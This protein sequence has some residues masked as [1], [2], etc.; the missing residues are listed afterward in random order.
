MR[1]TRKIL[2]A[3]LVLMTLM[4]GAF[5]VTAS[6]AAGQTWT[7]AG[8]K[9]LCGTDWDTANKNNDMTYDSATD[10]YVKVYENV[11]AGTYQFKCAKDHKW[12][13]SYGNGSANYN[14]KVDKDGSTVTITLKGTTV[15][16]K[17][18]APACDHKY[19]VTSA[20]VTCLTGG[21]RT[22]TCSVCGDSYTEEKLDALGHSYDANGQ[23]V[24]CDATTTF[25]RVYVNNA[26]KWANVYCYTWDTNPYVA[27]PGAQMAID[28]ATGYYYYDIPE[29]FVN[30][31]FNN[32]GSTQSA[33]LK[34]PT[35]KA[36]VYNNSTKAWS[37]LH[38]CSFSDATCTEPAKCECGKT[39]G[40]ALGHNYVEG[41]CS[42]CGEAA[43]CEHEYERV[44]FGHPDIVAP[45]CT[46]PGVAVYECSKCWDT[47]T[48][49]APIDP[50]AHDF[51]Y[52]N[53]EVITPADCATM[54]DGL[55]KVTCTYCNETKEV[56]LYAMHNMEE[57]TVPATCT[58]N[59]SYRAECKVCGYVE[60][61]VIEAG[62]HCNYSITCGQTG[63]CIECGV[64]FTKEHQGD[65]ATCTDPMFCYNCWS[66]VGEALGHNFVEGVCSRCEAED[67]NY[68]PEAK[69]PIV[70]IS[71]LAEGTTAGGELIA[72]TGI[73]ASAGLAIDAN[74]KSIDGF[75]FTLRLKLG[76][77]M[78]VE[79]G[80]VKAGIEIKTN[81]AAK[82]IVYAISSSSSDSTRTLQL[83][84]LVDGA[85]VKLAETAG[86]DGAAIAKYELSVDAAG[87]YYLG[88]TKSGINLYYIAVEEVEAPA[89]VNTLVVGETNKIVV[90]GNTLNAAGAPIEWV[91]FVV[92]EKAHYEFTG[93]T[94]AFIYNKMDLADFTAC[95]C[96]FDGKAD[97][98]PGTYYICVGGVVA[99]EFNITVTMSAI[100]GGDEP[101]DP[102][103]TP[104]LPELVLGDNAVVIDGSQT[105]LVGK[106]V[107]WY[108][109]TP[110]NAGV[111][112]FA[113]SDLTVYIL[114]SQNMADLN[115]YV[116]A[117]GVA[118]LEAGVQY[119]VLVGK[120][121][122]TG[123]FTLN[124]SDGAAPVHKNIIVVGDNHYIISD[125]LLGIG[126]EFLAVEITE[127]GTYVITGGAPMQVYF[128]TVPGTLNE[129]S[130]H[131][132]NID[133]VSLEFV[134][135]FEVTLT[136]AGTYWIGFRYDHVGD[137]REFD[138]NISLKPASEQPD[139]TPDEQ[140]EQPEEKPEQPAPELSLFEKIMQTI[141]EFIAKITAWFKSFI[142]GLKK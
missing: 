46:T 111:Y 12:D 37:E 100:E 31:I 34:T 81:G 79:D 103:V 77:T 35:G 57:T 66:S 140:P 135:S 116:G 90:S 74:N 10:S 32:G 126:Y 104:A 58:E 22:W 52:D 69:L 7:V 68:V 26:A 87:T 123:E 105:N 47:Y 53:P 18:E 93:D 92:T 62:G 45:T 95:V 101:V 4:V 38:T 71:D 78:K 48:E 21:N 110:A 49:E 89:H 25:I 139:E 65:P 107:A 75:D 91:E 120:D 112:K 14:L 13:V 54:T 86:V 24:R 15:T 29:N 42:R 28:E 142:A 84:T 117:D 106:A 44:Y 118:E 55:Q 83:A 73:S 102:P 130:P 39:Q 1:N 94:Y 115:A 121:G 63:M 124:I 137:E 132:V 141:N 136:E 125:T 88:S 43:P 109:F 67:P 98:E 122:V 23:C 8:V 36:V 5:A 33:D 61:N 19:E 138:I 16:A 76:G 85:L 114:T 60:E 9:A 51:D 134:D 40:E 30:V 129:S 6:A 17:V 133:G 97:L 27:W 72:G 108:T 70:N 119:F 113:C 127:P 3:L 20:T 128:F 2:V 41:V 59:G 56:T 64:E 96:G 80:V 82:I 11:K 50:E 99:G 131:K